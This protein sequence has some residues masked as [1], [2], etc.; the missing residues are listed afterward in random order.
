MWLLKFHVAISILCLMSYIGVRIAFTGR[1]KRFE[2]KKKKT[3]KRDY[4]NLLLFFCPVFNVTLAITYWYMALCDDVT[5]DILR[6]KYD[7]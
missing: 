1:L 2:R 6:D 4:L 5:A 7:E 3:K